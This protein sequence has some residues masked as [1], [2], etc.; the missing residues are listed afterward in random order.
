VVFVHG[1][2]SDSRT[3]WLNTDGTESVF[4]PD[5]LLKDKRS[6]TPDIFLG[7]FF[8]RTDAT[9]YDLFACAK[10]LL[11][12]LRRNDD[13]GNPG[14]LQQENLV[15]VC[16]S[17][18]GIVARYM[19][20]NNS[21]DFAKKRVGLILIA[22]PST[23]SR[24]ADL[25]ADIAVV[26]DQQLAKQL[27]WKNDLL[28]DLDRHFKDLVHDEKRGFALVGTE[29]YENRFVLH[30][31]WLPDWVRV[32]TEG[33]AGRYFGA[34][35]LLRETDHF[36]SV[37]PESFAH[38]AHELVVDFLTDFMR[39]FEIPAPVIEEPAALDVPI[40]GEPLIRTYCI[41]LTQQDFAHSL[42]R[43]LGLSPDGATIVLA[44][45]TGDIC[46]DRCDFRI[47]GRTR[48]S[49]SF[50]DTDAAVMVALSES[51][52]SLL[53]QGFGASD[54]VVEGWRKR[55]D[56]NSELGRDASIM[57]FLEKL[58]GDIGKASNSDLS[59]SL[60]SY[61][62]DLPEDFDRSFLNSLPSPS[63]TQVIIE[64]LIRR[65]AWEEF[66][67]TI[68]D[69]SNGSRGGIGILWSCNVVKLRSQ[70]QD[71][72]IRED[73]ERSK[74]DDSDALRTWGQN[75]FEHWAADSNGISYAKW[76]I[77]KNTSKSTKEA[78]GILKNIVAS[79]PKSRA[80]E[81]A[82]LLLETKKP[83]K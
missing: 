51:A 27:A 23:G 38:P 33:S 65:E 30:R 15:F 77:S 18:G 53:K 47:A 34:P 78:I 9:N 76:L 11:G 60:T 17:T 2:F 61:A 37:K 32:V 55:W 26:Y 56:D 16:H 74:P 41:R 70:I 36:S 29:A 40:K 50:E 43:H 83:A 72:K 22:S 79:L 13:E 10:E 20:H 21:A 52:G 58:T 82:K 14:P 19:L 44:E 59:H 69:L 7:G 31:K 64:E 6:G 54:R 48:V 57:V 66:T 39:R 75:L 28:V 68:V 24:L 12:A 4:W 67:S 71:Q 25:F 1:I 62:Y 46:P 80:A 35:T 5:L 45:E 42:A 81:K 3:C 63:P 8:T 73:L 49:F